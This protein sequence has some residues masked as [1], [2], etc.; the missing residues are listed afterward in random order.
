[1]RIMKQLTISAPNRPGSL[2]QIS[3][4]LSDGK[5]NI[6]ALAIS[7]T[8]EMGIL[9]IVVDKADEA[10]RLLKPLH[11]MGETDV[12]VV[13]MPNRPGSLAS[14]TEKLGEAHIN[15]SYA[16][17]STGSAGGQSTVVLKVQYPEKAMAVLR[18][19]TRR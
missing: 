14:I 16:Y 11:E 13:D 17:A 12:L 3:R 15:I 2:A 9:R 8:A 6:V 19:P 5:V 4:A 1:M 10:R 18:A 7:D